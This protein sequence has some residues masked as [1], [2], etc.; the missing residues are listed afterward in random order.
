MSGLI[1]HVPAEGRLRG[2]VLVIPGG[3]YGSLSEREGRPYAQW[4]AGLG[5][6]AYVL[7][8]S[9]APARWPTAFLEARRALRQIRAATS[10]GLPVG[11]IGSSAGAH[12]S[13][14]L[15]TATGLDVDDTAT[16]R[17]DFAILA[18]PVISFEVD[19]HE[20]SRDNLLGPDSSPEARRALSVERNVDSQ[21]PPT[22]L[23]TTATDRTVSATN[24]LRYAESLVRADVSVEVHVFPSGPHALALAT[25]DPVVGIWTTL[26]A[27]WLDETL[28]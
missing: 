14:A 18:Y 12:L 20:G 6:D 13:A 25:D 11:V 8:Y 22:F 28:S 21:T 4:L 3:G 17:P 27:R 5:F 7:T 23:W 9:V 15:S 2:A 1:T 19:A 26:A 24:T 16:P 10:P